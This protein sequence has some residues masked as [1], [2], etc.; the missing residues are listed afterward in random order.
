MKDNE[1]LRASVSRETFTRLETIVQQLEKWQPRINLVSP[2]TM[3]QIWQ[4]HILDSSQI[5][6]LFPKALKWIDLGSGGGFPGLVLGAFLADVAGANITLVESNAKKCAFLRETARIAKLPVRVINK[7]IEDT[8]PQT[9][10]VFDVVTARALASLTDLATMALPLLEKG[11]IGVFPKGQDVDDE[12]ECASTSWNL[13]YD[14]VDS[15]T[16]AQA[17]IV[18]LRSLSKRS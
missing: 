15:H 12:I 1:A 4:R 6:F 3:S 16:D 8:V 5:Y 17:R 2:N 10:E 9:T 14:L 11:T 13:G 7:R 18:V